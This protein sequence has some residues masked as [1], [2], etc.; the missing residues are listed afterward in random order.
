VLQHPGYDISGADSSP[1]HSGLMATF[2]PDR[3]GASPPRLRR[4][5]RCPSR[6]G[7]HPARMILPARQRRGHDTPDV[8]DRDAV[9]IL[10]AEISRY[11]GILYF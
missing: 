2:L 5:Q 3:T 11:F 6:H 8:G 4:S 9:P 10:C 7:W 1:H